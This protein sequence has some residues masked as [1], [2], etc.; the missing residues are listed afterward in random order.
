MPL[1]AP[2]A[3]D[4]TLPSFMFLK[5]SNDALNFAI[6]GGFLRGSVNGVY[7]KT[8]TGK[9]QLV[10]N[11][12]KNTVEASGTVCVFDSDAANGWAIQAKLGLIKSLGGTIDANEVP[13]GSDALDCSNKFREYIDSVLSK[14]GITIYNPIDEESLYS[15]IVDVT[16][17]QIYD[18]LIVD[19]LTLYFKDENTANRKQG[20]REYGGEY[21]PITAKI[22]IVL[23][24]YA[25]MGSTVICTL[26]RISEIK[27]RANDKRKEDY[28]EYVGGEVPGYHFATILETKRDVNTFRVHVHKNRGNPADP[29]KGIVINMV[30]GGIS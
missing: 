22:M 16:S 29:L 8:G 26:Q 12:A 10:Q 9:S 21:L 13:A 19:S 14:L 11:I 18:L 28:R 23:D 30:S 20:N 6:G 4:F 2:S 24:H 27:T 17:A 3:S 25:K 15:Q 1:N 5:T 7:G